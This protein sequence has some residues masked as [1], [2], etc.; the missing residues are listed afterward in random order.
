MSESSTKI[1]ILNWTDG[2]GVYPTPK[3]VVNE[4]CTFAFNYSHRKF[5]NKEVQVL[6]IF[7]GDGRLGRTI[8]SELLNN[9][10]A[11]KVTFVEVLKDSI[12]KIPK[13]RN[14]TILNKNVFHYHPKNKF[15]LVVSNP[16][17]LVLNSKTAEEL[18]IDW[19]LAKDSSKN[20]YALSIIKGLELC[21]DGGILCVIAPFG[22]LR[23]YYSEKFKNTLEKYCEKIIVKAN[24]ARNLF[25][26]VNQDIGFQLFVKRTRNSKN[27]LTDWQFGYNGHPIKSITNFSEDRLNTENKSKSTI[28]VRVG[29]IVWNRS[30]DNLRSKDNTDTSVVIYGS[31]IKQNHSFNFEIKKLE[32]RQFITN[33]GLLKNDII[34]K[35]AILFRRTLRGKPGKW[36]IDSAILKN[37]D[38][39]TYTA[40]NH[41]IVIELDD[42][43][44]SQ[45]E[46]IRGMI[47]KLIIEYYYISGSPTI[48]TKVVKSL[49]QKL[50]L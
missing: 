12:S 49:I 15:D 6:D 43:K 36:I 8:E 46:I 21:K 30:S 48:S 16:P 25:E 14:Y 13:K 34:Q 39:N 32:S 7:S 20:L 26:G 4:F 10:Y 24:D 28:N 11:P 3:E 31:N 44:D 2:V 41:T 42:F 40:E 37:D 50:A 23:G 27:K 35:P 5:K 29:P 9:T 33:N 18:G 1:E 17:Y 45:I 22:Y 47:S 38:S 19:S